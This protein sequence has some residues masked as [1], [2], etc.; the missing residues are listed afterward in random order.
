MQ[1]TPKSRDSVLEHTD[2]TLIEVVA[3]VGELG[4]HLSTGL[5]VE[6]LVAR[7]PDNSEIDV[8]T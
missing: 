1:L 6:R 2:G 5:I 8:S 4:V 7:I 3:G